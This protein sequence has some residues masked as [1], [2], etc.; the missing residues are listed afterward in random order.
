MRQIHPRFRFGRGST[1]TLA[2]RAPVR[3]N[4]KKDQVYVTFW[5]DNE[6]KLELSQ[7]DDRLVIDKYTLYAELTQADTLAFAPG[8]FRVQIRYLLHDGTGDVSQQML[9]MVEHTQKDGELF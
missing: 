2:F 9:G 8:L 7:A 5:Q 4:R 3:I 1:P 6:T